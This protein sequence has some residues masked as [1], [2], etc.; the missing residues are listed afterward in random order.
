M[1]AP[2]MAFAQAIGRWGNFVNQE[3]Y[4]APTSL[5]WALYIP[6]GKRLSGYE[7]FDTFHPLFLYES[8]WNAAAGFALLWISARFRG[9][10]R[11]GDVLLLY[12]MQYAVIRFLLDFVR[13]DSHGLGPLTTAQVVSLLTCFAAG[14][15]LWWRHR[16][17]VILPSANR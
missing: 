2:G 12:L 15:W 14:A 11:D 4:G 5:P 9:W 1:V 17:G 10:L 3:L 6:P 8:L 7:G 13:L 16:T